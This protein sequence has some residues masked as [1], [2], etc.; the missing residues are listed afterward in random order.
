MFSRELNN[1][2]EV[3]GTVMAAP[4]FSHEV[5]G[6]KFDKFILEI[7]RLSGTSDYINVIISE[8][9]IDEGLNLSE[10]EKVYI[11]G[12]FRSYN[13]YNGEGS[14]LVLSVFVKDIS[15]I[16]DE[17]EENCNRILLNGF[18]CKDPIYRITPFGREITDILVAVNRIHNKSDYIPCIIWGRN[19]KVASLMKTG[20]RIS[21]SGRIQ[22]REYRKKLEDGETITK[23]AYEV[24][25]CKIEEEE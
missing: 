25:V 14:K 3:S 18:L 12:Q 5:S 22:S 17:L 21:L 23:T 10:N 4:M 15:N 1:Y 2:C 9:F 16:Y 20:D 11:R 19:A 6:E 24:S 7:R 8:R 13:N